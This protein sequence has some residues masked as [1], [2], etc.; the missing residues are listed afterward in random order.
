MSLP[1]ELKPDLHR[2]LLGPLS[3]ADEIFGA[4]LPGCFFT[5]LLLIK[6]SPVTTTAMAYPNLGYK[7][8]IACALLVSYVFGKVALA[9]VTGIEEIVRKRDAVTKSGTLL[10][11]LPKE[12]QH[13][14]GG[15]I[16]GAAT[17]GKFR[18]LE[19]FAGQR[20]Q[21]LFNLSTGLLL[22]LAATIHGDGNLRLLEAS[23]GL[24]LLVRGFTVMRNA[25][26]AVSGLFGV[27]VG[28]R[29]TEVPLERVL[30]VSLV[31]L[32]LLLPQSQAATAKPTTET[33]TETP[34]VPPLSQAL[35]TDHKIPEQTPSTEVKGPRA[36]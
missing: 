21:Y 14:V 15:T 12:L 17:A 5:L 34:P 20:A 1:D 2:T 31:I 33:T 32:K 8:K 25:M 26:L 24:I 16:L 3:L 6:G 28:E 35:H 7:T 29:L 18:M 13:F 30:Q 10:D 22:M 9:I 27:A 11:N 4:F 19:Y 36:V 23:L